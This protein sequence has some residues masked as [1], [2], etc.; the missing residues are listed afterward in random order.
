MFESNFPPAYQKTERVSVRQAAR[1][2]ALQHGSPGARYDSQ[3]YEDT[4]AMYNSAYQHPQDQEFSAPPQSTKR[5]APSHD[6]VPAPKAKKPRKQRLAPDGNP[7]TLLAVFLV[8]LALIV[9]FGFMTA[10]PSKR[11]FNAKKRA[12]AAQLTAQ[13][14]RP[15]L[16]R[17]DAEARSA[18]VHVCLDS[19]TR[20]NSDVWTQ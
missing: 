3:Y 2:T 12:D 15:S 13:N 4:H 19:G 5:P 18:F 7:G 17:T 11:G 9:R 10:A 8:V 20:T 14:G 16:L 6:E 1:N